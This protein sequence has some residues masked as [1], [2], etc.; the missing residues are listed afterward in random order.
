MEGRD[1]PLLIGGHGWSMENIMRSVSFIWQK[2]STEFHNNIM[3]IVET[4]WRDGMG[5]FAAATCRNVL[6]IT[7]EPNQQHL[8][9]FKEIGQGFGRK[10]DLKAQC[11]RFNW[12][13]Y[14]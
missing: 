10:T 2:D 8:N 4:W 14:W 7:R 11:V 6:V 9:G 12:Y 3:L 1:G 13:L 5:C